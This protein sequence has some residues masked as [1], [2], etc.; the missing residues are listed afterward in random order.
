[1]P[2]YEYKCNH[3]HCRFELKQSFKD[4]SNDSVVTCPKC[5]GKASRVFSPVP[6]IFKGSGFYTT[7]AKRAKDKPSKRE[8][9]PDS[10]D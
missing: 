3:C 10:E 7:D 8:V 9:K 6:I 2:V 5:G 1:M 4:N